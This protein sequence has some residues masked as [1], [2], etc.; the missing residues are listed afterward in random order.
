M[1]PILLDLPEVIETTRLD[2]RPPMPGDGKKL[3]DAKVESH[4]ELSK[5]LPWAVEEP[6]LEESETYVRK[7][8]SNWIVR[9]DLPL[10]LFKK[11]DQTLVGASGLHPI[12]WNVPSFEIGYWQRTSSCGLGYMTE[13]VERLT[14]FALEHLGARRIQIRVDKENDRSRKV[15]EKLGYTLEGVCKGDSVRVGGTELRD[16]LVYAKIAQ[17]A[18]AV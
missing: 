6:T 9:E 16:T 1:K 5:W 12:D 3:F 14:E 2:I 4:G 15:P 13:C 10:F 7:A 18:H 17:V 11:D 8:Y